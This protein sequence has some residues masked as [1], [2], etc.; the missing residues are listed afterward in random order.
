MDINQGGPTAGYKD[1][2]GTDFSVL[3]PRRRRR[4]CWTEGDLDISR[5]RLAPT[6]GWS[7]LSVRE[8]F[9]VP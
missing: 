6:R 2:P 5:R 9:A 7:A 3:P 4:L 8:Q 1:S